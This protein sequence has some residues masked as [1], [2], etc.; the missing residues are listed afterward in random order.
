MTRDSHDPPKLSETDEHPELSVL[1][2][3]LRPPPPLPDEIRARVACDLAAHVRAAAPTP[4]PIPKRASSL[5]W[6]W[7]GGSLTAAAAGLLLAAGPVWNTPE[8]SPWIRPEHAPPP[9][10]GDVGLEPPP[11]PPNAAP[12]APFGDDETTLGQP[13]V[14]RD[15]PRDT[16]RRDATS[17]AG[18]P[19]LSPHDVTVVLAARRPSLRSCWGP[20]ATPARLSIALRIAS[21]GQVERVTATGGTASVRA[22]VERRIQE[23]T[24]PRRPGA[25]RTEFRLAFAPPSPPVDPPDSRPATVAR[26]VDARARQRAVEQANPAAL[27]CWR[28]HGEGRGVRLTVEVRLDAEGRPTRVHATGGSARLTECVCRV[29]ERLRVEGA[30]QATRMSFPLVFAP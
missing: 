2:Q 22:Y 14:H 27:A 13:R 29:L 21:N 23:W 12:G 24:F 30:G 26:R 8:T 10:E 20:D 1:V 25:T 4:A 17:G 6:A 28:E 15:A 11:D 7:L 16:G 5:R 19:G 18:S 9:L 3:G